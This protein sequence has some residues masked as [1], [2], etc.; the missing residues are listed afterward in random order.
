[1]YKC[2]KQ[3]P[4]GARGKV[5]KRASPVDMI[6]K[7]GEGRSSCFLYHDTKMIHECGRTSGYYIVVR[8]LCP[9]TSFTFMYWYINV[10][11][12]VFTA[13]RK[14]TVSCAGTNHVRLTLENDSL[15]TVARRYLLIHYFSVSFTAGTFADWDTI[16]ITNH[17]YRLSNTITEECSLIKVIEV[18]F[19]LA[20]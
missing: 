1:M 5:M 16:L 2:G 15:L 7:A 8:D 14:V 3:E 11:L 19:V 12:T 17:W 13:G 4:C 10:S 18:V 9:V 6:W 20:S